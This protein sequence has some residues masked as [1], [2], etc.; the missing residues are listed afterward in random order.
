MPQSYLGLD[1]SKAKIHTYLI[2]V[3][4]QPKRKV[5]EN[6]AEGHKELV[7]WL[8]RH[9][10][11]SLHACL[12]ATSIYGHGVARMLHSAG[13]TVSICNPKAIHAYGESRMMRTKTDAVDA[14]LIAE[15]CRDHAPHP[16]TPPSPEIEH[17]QTLVRRVQ[18]LEQMIGQETNR[19]ETATA[20]LEAEIQ[21]HIEFLEQQQQA[22]W[23]RILP[24]IEQHPD[25]KQACEL[26][27]SIPG[28]GPESAARII[29]EIGDWTVF[30]SARQLAAYVGITPQEKSSGTSVR[31][32]T[33]L[34][35]LGNAR[36]RKTLFFP[37]LTLLRWNK[38]IQQWREQM[39]GRG[40]TRKQVVGAVM[41]KV[42][43]WVFG[44]LHSGKPFD[45]QIAFPEAMA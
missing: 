25:L 13:Y 11:G 18:A 43:R 3:E 32:K 6:T 38:T 44:V 30:K 16:W 40:K 42:I 34:C 29:A 17:L 14:R 7:E 31:G 15:Y 24:H 9:S 33:R 1:I 37:A 41:H 39:L 35:K 20:D 28:I 10:V 26:L 22:L 27:D 21:S 5:V 12:E 19:L 8:S 23:E 45:P 36:L 4:R 2:L